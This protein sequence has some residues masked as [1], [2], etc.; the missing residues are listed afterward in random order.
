MSTSSTTIPPCSLEFALRLEGFAVHASADGADLL[1]GRPPGGWGCLVVDYNLQLGN[2]LD[3]I[4]RLRS[5]GILWPAILM[6]T[7]PAAALRERAAD[8][9]ILIVEKPL[10]GDALPD[11]IRRSFGG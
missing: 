11:A 5:R 3:L 1:A 9:G 8:A 10:L 2:G 7:A 6:T 4:A